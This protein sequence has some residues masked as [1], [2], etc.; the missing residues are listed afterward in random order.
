M[1]GPRAGEEPRERQRIVTRKGGGRRDTHRADQVFNWADQ[2]AVQ[3]LSDSPLRQVQRQDL[4]LVFV[5]VLPHSQCDF[6]KKIFSNSVSGSAHIRRV[7]ELR[8]SVVPLL[9][10]LL[11][12][13][14]SPAAGQSQLISSDDGANQQSGNRCIDDEGNPQV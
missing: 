13:V 5:L 2:R 14:T 4:R 9:A 12:L 8:M 6:G 3:L 1:D 7:A 11:L 10:S